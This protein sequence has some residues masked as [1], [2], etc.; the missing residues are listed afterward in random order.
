MLWQSFREVDGAQQ[1]VESIQ[2]GLFEYFE[3]LWK[4]LTMGEEILFECNEVTPR[5]RIV[6]PIQN[7]PNAVLKEFYYVSQWD[8]EY[9]LKVGMMQR[10]S[11]VLPE[12]EVEEY[13]E[14]FMSLTELM[15]TEFEHT[16]A[17]NKIVEVIAKE[18]QEFRNQG[19]FFQIFG[20]VMG[21]FPGLLVKNR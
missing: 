10:R 4:E 5:N 6:L 13:V 15:Q 21:Y 8:K 12:Q 2:K 9:M 14:K 20:W 11:V 1:K 3:N 18:V 19:W 16:E 17:H 7:S